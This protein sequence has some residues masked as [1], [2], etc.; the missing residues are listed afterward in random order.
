MR[1]RTRW[2]AEFFRQH[3]YDCV[4]SC[5]TPRGKK[6][7]SSVRTAESSRAEKQVKKHASITT[8]LLSKRKYCSIA[9]YI[10]HGPTSSYLYI[11]KKT[12]TQL[13]SNGVKKTR[14][15]AFPGYRKIIFPLWARHTRRRRHRFPHFVFHYPSGCGAISE[16]FFFSFKNRYIRPGNSRKKKK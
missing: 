10:I 15:P 9:K 1:F 6:H 2:A 14:T 7:T 4:V 8:N 5:R 3:C 16:Y 13:H 12:H 11:I